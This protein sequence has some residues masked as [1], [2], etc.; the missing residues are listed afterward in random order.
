MSGPPK[1]PTALK[2]ARGTLQ[3]CRTPKSEPTPVPGVPDPP[4]SM[5]GEARAEWDRIAPEL[6]KLGVLSRIDRTMLTL[7][8]EAWADYLD[9]SEK[10]KTTGKVLK[11]EAGNFQENPY[12]SIKKR[13]AELCHKFAVE[14][15]MSAASRTRIAAAPPEEDIVQP[16]SRYLRMLPGGKKA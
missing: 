13:C 3:P 12:F 10:V 2:K 11:T 8:C 7:Y 4:A 1:L 6:A 16:I 9:A 15:G 14:F 5:D